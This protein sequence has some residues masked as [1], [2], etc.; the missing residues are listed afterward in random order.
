MQCQRH[1]TIMHLTA[2]RFFGGPERQILG[3]AKGLPDGFRSVLVSFAENG[4]C[5]AFLDKAQETGFQAVA[6][7]HD[8]PRL[9]A[10]YRELAQLLRTLQADVL[11]CHG[12]KANLLGLIAAR[13]I[14]IP[15]IAV[16]R[17]WTA[18]CT[19]VRLYEAIDRRVLR[20]M[21]K[22]VCVSQAQA[23]KVRKA[24]VPQHKIAVIPNAIRPER[25]AQP[26]PEYR[27]RLRSLFRNPPRLIVGAAGRLSPEKGF[28]VLVDAAA[29]VIREQPGVGFVL[30]GDGALRE[31]LKR[32]IEAS[33]LNGNFVLAGF[34]PDFDQY[35]PHLDLLAVPSFTEGLPNVVLEAFAAGV[36][37]VATAVGGTPELVQDGQSG[38][39]TPPGDPV[40]LARRIGDLATQPGAG[41]EM[42]LR[43]RER[44]VQD[45]TFDAQ[46]Q[47]YCRLF[48]DLTGRRIAAAN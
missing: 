44:V 1:L 8:T 31:S 33:G 32:Q 18:E 6:L 13:R 19:R 39:L 34:R 25:F 35:L 5:Q 11:C 40:A 12:Y 22:V 7:T 15:V 45:F 16:S 28:G 30:F 21:D 29:Q 27:E 26:Q 36:P 48:A 3:L 38:Y 24:G 9:W 10:A 47:Q 2:S 20:W 42:G 23:E 14:R 37:V 41:R 17:G 46:A 4:L 43:G